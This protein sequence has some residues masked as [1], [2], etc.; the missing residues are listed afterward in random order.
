MKFILGFLFFIILQRL[1]TLET[2][3]SIILFKYISQT[4]EMLATPDI[5]TFFQESRIFA[6]ARVQI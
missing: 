4:T 3:T 2:L 6:F 5:E 1:I